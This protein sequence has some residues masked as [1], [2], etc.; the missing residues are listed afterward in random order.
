M[1]SSGPLDWVGDSSEIRRY[2]ENHRDRFKASQVNNTGQWASPDDPLI[3]LASHQQCVAKD[4]LA[5]I[6]TAEGSALPRTAGN[7]LCRSAKPS[8]RTSRSCSRT[9]GNSRSIAVTVCELLVAI[10]VILHELR[11]AGRL[12]AYGK[13][14]NS[15]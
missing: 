6:A 3:A 14:G 7:T 4:R 15:A 5:E 2:R 11:F 10:T 8:M 12:L 1:S 13:Y 9:A